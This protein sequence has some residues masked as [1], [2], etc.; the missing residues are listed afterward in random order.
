M[1]MNTRLQVEHPVT[2]M[3]T[4]QDLVEWQLRVAAGEP[5]PL[6]QDA[7]RIGGHSIE[8]RVYAENTEKGFLPSTGTLRHLAT[9]DAARFEVGGREGMPAAVRIDSGVRAGDTISPYY[10]PMIAKL[11]VWG[12]D[13]DEAIRR[14]RQALVRFEVVGLATNVGFLSRLMG[15][16]SFVDADLDT[17]LIERERSALLPATSVPTPRQLA[18]ASAAVLAI[19]AQ[20]PQPGVPGDPFS[21][22]NGWRPTAWLRRGFEFTRKQQ[23]WAVEIEYARNGYSARGAGST[24]CISSLAYDPATRRVRGLLDAESFEIGAVLERETLSLFLAEGPVQLGF[25]PRL[26]HAGEEEAEGERLTAP[27][28]GK[29]I[30]VLCEKG[31]SVRK[32]QALLVMEAMKMEHT[33]SAPEDGVVVELRYTVGDQVNEGAQLVE[34]RPE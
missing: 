31:A 10:D 6:A 2:E 29:V 27:M 9:P 34:I 30:A 16:R 4:G 25:A 8:A 23:A 15:C 24:S 13:R 19:E 7:L 20:A 11:I 28:P 21:L 17:G 33:L 18:I 22:C 26:A 32:G 3:I 1:E 5:L 12:G 14:M